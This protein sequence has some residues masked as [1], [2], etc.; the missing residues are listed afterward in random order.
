M[1]GRGNAWRA[2]MRLPVR[3]DTLCYTRACL[4]THTHGG[5]HQLKQGPPAVDL[6]EHVR[7]RE[8]AAAASQSTD[9]SALSAILEDVNDGKV[10]VE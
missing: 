6:M 4:V 2:C 7:M 3:R 10:V 1:D 5:C 9:L 8:G